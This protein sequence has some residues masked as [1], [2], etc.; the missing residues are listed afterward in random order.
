M[1]RPGDLAVRYGGEEFTLLLPNTDAQ[2]A[3]AIVQ[4]I[5]ML[6]RRQVIEHAGSPLGQVSASAG[7]AVG[8]P[9]A[10]AITPE[11]LTAAAD[12]ALYEAKRQG[13]DRYSLASSALAN[14]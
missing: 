3:V 5:L 14:C 12:A 13:R 7:I 4:E 10:E 1:K 9:G 8:S 6:L 11:S 2:G